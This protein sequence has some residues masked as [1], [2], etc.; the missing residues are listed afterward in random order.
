M[1]IDK[2]FAERARNVS[3]IFFFYFYFLKVYTSLGM[4]GPYLRLDICSGNFAVEGN[5]S[6]ILDI[7]P[8]SFSTKFRKI[9]F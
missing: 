8:G 9:I 6:Q 2:E 3:E 5:V 1:K 4:H 7:G